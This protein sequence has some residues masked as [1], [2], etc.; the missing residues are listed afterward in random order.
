MKITIDI[1]PDEVKELFKNGGILGLYQ[2]DIDDDDDDDDTKRIFEC[3][4]KACQTL[5]DALKK[6]LN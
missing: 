2:D 6:S 4:E 1:T 3:C 5:A